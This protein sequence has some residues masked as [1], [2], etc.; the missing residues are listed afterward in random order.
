MRLMPAGKVYIRP[1]QDGFFHKPQC[2][3]EY[4]GEKESRVFRHRG[5]FSLQIKVKKGKKG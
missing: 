5:C 1:P 3:A 2:G 4:K